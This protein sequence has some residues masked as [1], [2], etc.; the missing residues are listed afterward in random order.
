MYIA[1]KSHEEASSQARE[2]ARFLKPLLENAKKDGS[3]EII[4]NNSAGKF[5]EYGNDH[6]YVT[7]LD[8]L[9]S[10]IEGATWKAEERESGVIVSLVFDQFSELRAA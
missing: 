6:T 2:D 7:Y 5:L 8:T 10:L 9:V 4:V 3:N 1:F